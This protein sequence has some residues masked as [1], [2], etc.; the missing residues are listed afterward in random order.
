[1]AQANGKKDPVSEEK[2]VDW[3]SEQEIIAKDALTVLYR[4]YKGYQWGIEFNLKPS[5]AIDIMIIRLMDIPTDTVYIVRYPDIDRDR[6][7]CVMFGGGTL[8]E[9]HGLVAGHAKRSADDVR[10]LAKTPSG[11]IVPDYA[12]VPEVNPGYEK[13]K[14]EFNKLNG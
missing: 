3:S 6:M 9:A 10:G 5:G 7:K 11:L 4:E 2:P 1:M 8:L 12:A 14:R 13:I